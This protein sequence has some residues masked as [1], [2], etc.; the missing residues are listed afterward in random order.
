MDLKR[1]RYFVSVAEQ[2]TLASRQLGIAQPALSR[3][4]QKLE[5]ECGTPLLW[6]NGCGVQLSDVGRSALL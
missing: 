2:G 4:I 3:H 6:C 1:L 5:I